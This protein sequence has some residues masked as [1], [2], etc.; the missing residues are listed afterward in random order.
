M[1]S[2][3]KGK[4]YE[5][6]VANEL[7]EF[8][9]DAHRNWV[10]QAAQGGVDLAQTGDWGIEVKGGK[11]ANIVKTRKWL[12][13]VEEESEHKY[14]IVIARPLREEKYVLMN[15]STFKKI[16]KNLEGKIGG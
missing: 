2:R 5:L 6:E 16:L 7:K 10:G 13:Q 4:T 9:P 11:Q 3:N 15:F 14:K 8:F 12:D 1:N